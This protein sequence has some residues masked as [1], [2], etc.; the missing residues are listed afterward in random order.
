MIDTGFLNMFYFYPS[1]VKDPVHL[2]RFYLKDTVDGDLLTEAAR[3]AVRLHYFFGLRPV[4]DEKG[5]VWFEENHEEPPVF[6]DDGT[7]RFLGSDETNGYL[8]RVLYK[9]NCIAVSDM[10]ALSDGR[11]LYAFLSTLLYE[12]YTLSGVKIDPEGLVLTGEDAEDVRVRAQL[13]DEIPRGLK[14]EGVYVPGK[15]FIIPEERSLIESVDTKV[16]ALEFDAAPFLALAKENGGTPSAVIMTL[17][18]EILYETYEVADG[19]I[20]A[21]LPVDMRRYFTEKA[22]SNYCGAATVPFRKEWR[23]GSFQE[24]ILAVREELKI[25]TRKENL[26]TGLYP[27]LDTR[28]MVRAQSLRDSALF[29][30]MIRKRAQKE[31]TQAPY[32]YILTN[33]GRFPF[34]GGVLDRI[35]GLSMNAPNTGGSPL[36]GLFTLGDKMYLFFYQNFETDALPRGFV[37]KLKEHGIEAKMTAEYTYRPDPVKPDLFRESKG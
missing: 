26:I 16:Y 4:L 28:D 2:E 15:V 36:L 34:P 14:P 17:M 21:S 35:T 25:Q 33:V 30:A 31:K 7:P 13:L 32:T 10:H 12:Y 27:F 23:D 22:L 24:K 3:R 37:S 11:G 5:V 6:Y 29:D 1:S 9:D 20:S 19:E 8:F 18:S